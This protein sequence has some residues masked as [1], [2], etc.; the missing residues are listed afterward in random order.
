[1]KHGAEDLRLLSSLL[2]RCEGLRGAERQ[3]WID[4]LAGDAARLRPALVKMLAHDDANDLQEFLEHPAVRAALP[5]PAPVS[6]FKQ[7]D[8]IGPYRLLRPIGRG[9]MGEVWLATRSD[10]QLRRS[11]ALKLPILSV[12]RSVLAQR[13]ERERDILAALIHPHIA[14]LY[15]A[16][17]ADD[18]QPYMALEYIEGTPITQAADDRALDALGRVQLLRQVM[19]AVQYAHANLVIH[20]DLK[21]ANVLVTTDGQAKLLDFGIA[22]L[23]EAEAGVSPD[24]ELTQLSGRALTLRYAAPEL[25]QGSTV[26]TAVDIWALGVLLYELLAGTRPFEGQSSHRIE[27]AILTGHPPRPSQGRTGVIAR[28]SAGRASDLDTIVLKALRK[29]PA[30]RY[31]TA[32]AFAD[33]LDRWVRGQPVRAQRDSA[34]YRTRRFMARHALAVSAATL[35]GVAVIASASAAVVLGLQAREESARAVAAR[36]FMIELFRRA[37]PDLSRGQEVSARQL[38]RQGHDTVL[39]TLNGQP[40]LQAELLHS[41]GRALESMNDIPGTDA[42]YA[43]AAAGYQ[44]LGHLREAAALTIDRA[45][46]RLGVQ[47][48]VPVAVQLLAQAEALYPGHVKDAEFLARRAIYRTMAADIDADKPTKQLWYEQAQ[49]HAARGLTD[50]S[51]RTVFAVRVLAM[52]D[53]T[54][55]E[56]SLAIQRLQALLSRPKTQPSLVL[57]DTLSVLVELGAAERQAGRYSAALAHFDEA[58]ALCRRSLNPVGTQ[59]AYNNW[60]RA[61]GLLVMGLDEQ[62]METVPLLLVPPADAQDDWSTLQVAQ[63]Y[64][65]L[66]HNDRLGEFPQ[67][68]AHVAAAA[69]AMA[70]AEMHWRTRVVALIAQARHAL[71]AGDAQQTLVL[72]TQAQSLVN[73]HGAGDDRL[74]IGAQVLHALAAHSLGLHDAALQMLDRAHAVQVMAMGATHPASHLVSINRVRPLWALQR[75]TEAMT[76]IDQALPVLREAM[77]GQAP[78]LQRLEALRVQLTRAPQGSSPAPGRVEPFM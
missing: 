13:F 36:D 77:G 2:D 46:L 8:C 29:D 4:A 23:V 49:G 38:L 65:V 17:V 54:M 43:Q 34:W 18:G 53:G 24:S 7:G 70:G 71:R 50:T 60:H 44:R 19:D 31:A 33:D 64:V 62:A 11:V 56:H 37:D 14:R 48:E 76:L 41:V 9:G 40:L 55:G 1:M 3:A 25:I 12:R 10:G 63:A 59:C 58:Q 5:T 68:A 16:G 42:A 61:S 32:G 27:E 30:D 21:P 74:A 45:A 22:K 52:M 28:L 6:D 73:S 39:E 67:A 78:T 51:S 26:S 20:R 69:Q 66:S 47:T 75:Q 72:T 15:D 57:S 35:A